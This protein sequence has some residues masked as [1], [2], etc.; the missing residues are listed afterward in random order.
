MRNIVPIVV[1]FLVITAC[2]KEIYLKFTESNSVFN[3]NAIVEI[4]IPKAEGENTVSFAINSKIENHIANAL[5]FSE[6]HTDSLSLNDAVSKFDEEYSQ[7]KNDYEEGSLIWEAIF[8]GEVI[9]QSSEII[10]VAINTYTNTGG[11][12][13]NMNITLYNFNARTG[14]VIENEDLIVDA[15]GFT[16][17]IKSNFKKEIDIDSENEFGD[18]FFGEDFHLPA[19]IGFTDDGLLI[20]YNIYEIA[21]YAQGITEFT[22]PYEEIDNFIIDY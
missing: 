14:E 16:E 2:K 13:G 1:S 6:E 18:F 12:H 4:N 17:I 8:D 22:I 7:F 9:Y 19:N 15:T 21:S 3:I 10:C 11:A 20:L 5:S